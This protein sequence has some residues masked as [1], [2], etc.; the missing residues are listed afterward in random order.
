MKYRQEIDGLRALAVIPVVLFHAGISIFSGGFIGVDVFFVISGYL[1]TSILINDLKQQKFSLLSF[2][3]RRARRILPALLAMA[4]IT[5]AIAFVFMPPDLL[6]DYSLSLVNVGTFTS[7]FYFYVTSGYFATFAEEKPLLHTWSLAV[8]E[9]YYLIFPILLWVLWKKSKTLLIPCLLV[10][11]GLSFWYG[12]HLLKHNEL[13]A[14]FYLIFSR[15]WE[16]FF[17]SFLAFLNLKRIQS[18]RSVNEMASMLGLALILYGVFTFDENTPFPGFATLI[19]VIGTCLIIAFASP[20]VLVGKILSLHVFVYFGLMSYSLYLWHQPLLAFIKMKTVGTVPDELLWGAV[21]LSIILAYV[22]LNY[23]EKPFRN[24]TFLSRKQV[25]QWSISALVL[26][27][28]FGW[29]TYQ[30]NGFP[31]RFGTNPFKASMISSPM[32]KACHTNG[33]DYL[34]PEK[35]CTYFGSHITWAVLGDSHVVEPAYALAN[36]LK[37]QEQGLLHLSFSGCPNSYTLDLAVPKGCSDWHK[38][39]VAEILSRE[40]INNVM[41]SYRY[42]RHLFGDQ[43]SAYPGVPDKSPYMKISKQYRATMQGSARDNYW[44]SLNNTINKLIEAG[45]KVYIFY[46]IP[47]LPLHIE[48]ATTPFSIL[49]N[50]RVLDLEH[51]TTIKYYQ[52]RN[53]FILDKLNQLPYSSQLVAIKP[54]D[55]FCNESYCASVKNGKALYFDSDHLSLYGAELVMEQVDLDH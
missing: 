41:I 4:C 49:K 1:I 35:A 31:G 5:T 19:P 33:L 11:T 16:L 21:L 23:I 53:Q 55:S 17:G 46:P 44:N 34:A 39:A 50:T 32:R 3:E 40:S 30:Q 13:D 29:L 38:E 27:V 2:Y 18:F 43:L 26:M 15:A 12:Q 37:E 14:N 10:L 22:S 36:R 25:F 45:K 52:L 8:E 54:T 20:R 48:K 24:K 6:K 42:S 9:Q 28:A 7:N 47:E 51:S